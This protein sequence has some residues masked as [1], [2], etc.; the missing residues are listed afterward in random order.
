[1]AQYFE[2]V[3]QNISVDVSE[4]LIAQLSEIGFEGFE[5]EAGILKA[6][7][8]SKDFD[9]SQ[10]NAIARQHSVSFSKSI[11]EETN[12][13][14]LWE[15]SFQPVIIGDLVAIRANFHEPIKDIKHEIVIT[16]KMSFGT[17]HHATTSLM[18]EQMLKIDFTGKT[19]LDFGT[20]TGILSILAEKLGAEKIIAIDHDDYSI[21][22]AMENIISNNCKKI[23]LIK[24]DKPIVVEEFDII[25]ANINKNVIVE[26]LSILKKKLVS[27][28]MLLLS[29]LL[30]GDK[31]EILTETGKL[32][33]EKKE[34]AE[35]SQWICIRFSH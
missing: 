32:S 1:M 13:N 30:I 6:F 25:L 4:L 9:E 15:S 20:G 21:E 27:G 24:L 14:Q 23:Q 17:G 33:L 29:G 12:W 18:I 8:P 3:F 2:I 34:I 35:K 28:G 5:E 26:N 7:I 31:D 22:N 16:P 11:I 19:V 10:L